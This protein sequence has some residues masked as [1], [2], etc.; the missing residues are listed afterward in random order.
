MNLQFFVMKIDILRRFPRREGA[1]LG[2]HPAPP[3]KSAGEPGHQASSGPGCPLTPSQCEI[4]SLVARGLTN[5]QIGETIQLPSWGVAPEIE[6]ILERLGLQ[7]RIQ[8]AAWA[9][10]H[11]RTQAG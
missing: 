9:L 4:A 10:E 6:A 5:R 1:A 7:N 3:D 8:I 11:G 2:S